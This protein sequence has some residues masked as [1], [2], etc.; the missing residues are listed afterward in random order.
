MGS[1][2]KSCLISTKFGVVIVRSTLIKK[3]KKNFKIFHFLANFFSW[4]AHAR[5]LKKFYLTKKFIFVYIFIRDVQIFCQF[6]HQKSKSAI[7]TVVNLQMGWNHLAP[8][9]RDTHKW[10]SPKLLGPW[11]VKWATLEIWTYRTSFLIYTTFTQKL[12]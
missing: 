9:D 8:G 6:W 5:P 3:T 12:C 11:V 1:K 4:S 2:N 7:F 10:C